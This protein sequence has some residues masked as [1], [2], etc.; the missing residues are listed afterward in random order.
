MTIVIGAVLLFLQLAVEIFKQVGT[1][2]H[3]REAHEEEE[4]Q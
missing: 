3:G 2:I 1:I 4:K